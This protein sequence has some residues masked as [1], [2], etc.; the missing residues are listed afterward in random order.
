MP[1]KSRR[2]YAFALLLFPLAL[3][4]LPVHAHALPPGSTPRPVAAAGTWNDI[5]NLRTGGMV[6]GQIVEVVPGDSLTIISTAT[7]QSKRFTWAELTSFQ[8]DGMKTEV[9]TL[10]APA[11]LPEREVVQAGPG[12]PRLH[13]EL[14]RPADLKLY[15]VTGEITVNSFGTGPSS[16]SI[17]RPICVAPC[18]RV[19]DGRSGQSFFFNGDGVLKSRKFSL[20]QRSGDVV[21]RVKPGRPG[22][23]VGGIAGM[24]VGGAGLGTAALLLLMTPRSTLGQDDGRS[25]S[26]RNNLPAAGMLIGGALAVAGGLAMLLLSSTRIK[27]SQR[28]TAARRRLG[29]G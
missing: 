5:V 18:D 19:I 29:A 4:G 10:A 24:A 15:E 21:A 8:R 1:T 27:W 14:T 2:R 13:I 22:L 9:A 6:R 26:N 11:A 3:G 25:L 16:G 17:Y 12:A 20:S 28:T 23:R 7:G